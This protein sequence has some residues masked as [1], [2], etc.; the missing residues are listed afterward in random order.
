MYPRLFVKEHSEACEAYECFPF[1]FSVHTA[2]LWLCRISFTMSVLLWQRGG[3]ATVG[4]GQTRRLEKFQEDPEFPRA[5]ISIGLESDFTPS[6]SRG[7]REALQKRWSKFYWSTRITLHAKLMMKDRPCECVR[8]DGGI[9][10]I[11]LHMPRCVCV[12]ACACFISPS[13]LFFFPLFLRHHPLYLLGQ[14]GPPEKKQRKN[15]WCVYVFKFSSVVGVVHWCVPDWTDIAIIARL[16]VDV[17]CWSTFW[18]SVRNC[19]NSFFFFS[20]C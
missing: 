17:L 2:S 6:S 15:C 14:K 20:F 16:C 5:L 18:L 8:G 7:K 19:Y 12:C 11:F 13:L 10:R 4:E 3:F 1:F 9:W